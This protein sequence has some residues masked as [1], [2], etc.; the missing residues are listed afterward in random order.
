MSFTSKLKEIVWQNNKVNFTN[1]TGF[2][3]DFYKHRSNFISI[4]SYFLFV[5]DSF[6][7]VFR[8]LDTVLFALP[9]LILATFRLPYDLYIERSRSADHIDDKASNNLPSVVERYAENV[10]PVVNLL[11][12]PFLMISQ[13]VLRTAICIPYNFI[14]WPCLW[15]MDK[16]FA[17]SSSE[18]YTLVEPSSEPTSR[19]HLTDHSLSFESQVATTPALLNASGVFSSAAKKESQSVVAIPSQNGPKQFFKVSNDLHDVALRISVS[20]VAS[21]LQ[22]FPQEIID[23]MSPFL[24]DKAYPG[25]WKDPSGFCDSRFL[26]GLYCDTG[27]ESFI[28]IYLKTL[29]EMLQTLWITMDE[30][31]FIQSLVKKLDAIPVDDSNYLDRLDKELLIFINKFCDEVIVDVLKKRYQKLNSY[32]KKQNVQ[33][34]GPLW[35]FFALIPNSIR[36][37]IEVNGRNIHI[38]FVKRKCGD[39]SSKLIINA[40]KKGGGKVVDATVAL[41]QRIREDELPGYAKMLADRNRPV[42]DHLLSLCGGQNTDWNEVI[43]V[44][45]TQV[46]DSDDALGLC[47]INTKVKEVIGE[48]YDKL[49]ASIMPQSMNELVSILFT[50]KECSENMIRERAASFFRSY[51]LALEGATSPLDDSAREEPF[52]LSID[53]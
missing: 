11:I 17:S 41:Y 38:H 31:S 50:S 48:Q 15:L 3:D 26:M 9:T 47:E 22:C 10:A 19:S 27:D 4:V 39:F 23:K 37:S 1:L 44:M 40:L 20:Y 6:L 45:V 43:K 5:G 13:V 30:Q 49:H 12:L 42:V 28:P 52:S 25:W 34:Q 35:S 2:F 14:I 53:C 33:L 46:Y 29:V 7:L 36:S 16:L 18:F 21:I 51:T 32:I 24:K 8:A